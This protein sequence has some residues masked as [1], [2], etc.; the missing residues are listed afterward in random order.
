MRPILPFI[1]A[2]GLLAVVAVL[3]GSDSQ[4]AVAQPEPT[5]TRDPK[6]YFTDTRL[7]TQDGR[8][9]RFYSDV[10]KGRVVVVN[11]MF[12]SC[13][14][15]CPLITRQMVEVRDELAGLF[16][17]RVFFVSITSDPLRDTPVAMKKF[18][19][20]QSA[21]SGGWTFL[22]GTRENVYSV[23]G[24]LGA[25][26][27]DVEDHITVLY[28]LDVDNKRMRRMLPNQPPAAIAEAVRVIATAGNE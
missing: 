17:T 19:K 25:R 8:T 16:G 11:V 3:S 26:P 13:K 5:G 27:E 15:A 7:L 20:D 10:L 4:A 22:T 9:V 28:I 21:D 23:L 1:A 2:T 18:A 14:D 12:T 6:A 24:R